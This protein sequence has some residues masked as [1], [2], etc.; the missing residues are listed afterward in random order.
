MLWI[1]RYLHTLKSYVSNKSRP[2]GSIA[3]GYI[4]EECATF[5]S[6]YLYDVETKHDCEERNYLIANNIRNEGLSIFKCM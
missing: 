3:E 6:R 5:C 4:I 2:K 1:D